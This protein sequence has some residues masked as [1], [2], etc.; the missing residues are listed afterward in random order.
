MIR[1]RL[2]APALSDW[3]SDVQYKRP[4]EIEQS[5]SRTLRSGEEIRSFAAATEPFYV[6]PNAPT[7]VFGPGVLADEEGPVAHA[8]IEYVK[9]SDIAAAT[10][11]DHCREH[12]LVTGE[13]DMS[14]T[15]TENSLVVTF[16]INP[17]AP[18][19][20]QGSVGRK[21]FSPRP[22]GG[23]RGIESRTVIQHTPKVLL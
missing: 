9:R 10:Y 20:R 21:L 15:A 12:P 14:V 6:A 2:A 5:A 22:V 16:L 18:I 7:V 8:D 17:D 13:S 3:N 4:D 11:P 23:E 1:L 19:T